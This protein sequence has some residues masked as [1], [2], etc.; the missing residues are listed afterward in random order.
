M[1]NASEKVCAGI[2]A[3]ESIKLVIQELEGMRDYNVAIEVLE[4]AKNEIKDVIDEY[5]EEAEREMM[6]E[7]DYEN[8]EY[9][10]SVI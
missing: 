7:L 4:D 5:Q 6:E 10:R 3:L 8:R 2:D 9:I 1:N